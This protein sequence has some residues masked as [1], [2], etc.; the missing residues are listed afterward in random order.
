MD[1]EQKSL[2]INKLFEDVYDGIIPKRVPISIGM[3]HAAAIDFA[4]LDLRIDQFNP[5]KL[6]QAMDH[7]NG[8]FDTD[9]VIGMGSRLPGLYKTLDANNYQMA[10]DGYV[11]HPNVY[12]IEADEYDDLIA[13]P[14]KVSW[15]KVLPR[16]YNGLNGEPAKVSSTLLKAY[17]VHQTAMKKLGPGAGKIAAKYGKYTAKYIT[18]RSRAPF[19]LLADVYRSFTGSLADIRR[20]P[21]K[22]LAAVEALTPLSLKM[23]GAPNKVDSKRNRASF[24]LHMAMYMRR[25]DMEKFW[26]PTFIE[27][28][29]YLDSLGYG[30]N[31]FAE[32]DW[33]RFIDLLQELPKG[34]RVQ[35]EYGDAQAIKDQLGDHLII[36]GLYPVHLLKTGSKQEVLDKAKEVMDILAPGGGYIFNFDKSI[37]RADDIVED[38]LHALLEFVKDYGKY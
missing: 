15:E 33:M 36:E 34:T 7:V 20:Y 14:V 26:W 23:A 8:R 5:D 31:L 27:V 1:M 28:L 37:L 18:K 25:S 3:D 35:F 32:Q 19:D 21:D 2:E 13:D 24:A 11:Q 38:N 30:I 29:N 10:D 22:V 16:Y 4:G 9:T 6:V 12:G 17:I